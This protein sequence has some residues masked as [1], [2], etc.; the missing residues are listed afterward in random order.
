MGGTNYLTT[1]HTKVACAGS[2]TTPAMFPE[3]GVKATLSL[4]AP[5]R[6]PANKVWHMCSHGIFGNPPVL[7]TES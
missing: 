2:L 3:T 6:M 1:C 5:T 4:S 7:T